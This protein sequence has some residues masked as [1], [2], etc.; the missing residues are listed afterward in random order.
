M[1]IHIRELMNNIEDS[2]VNIEEQNVVSSERIKELTRMKIQNTSHRKHASKKT[3]LTIGIAVAVVG[4]LGVTAFAALNGGLGR[5]SFGKSS[6]GPSI[7]EDIKNS[8]PAREFVSVVGYAD[9]P[10]Y[11]ATAEWLDFEDSY[12]SDR[13]ILEAHDA[14]IRRT[15]VDPFEEYNCYLV[16]SQE[17]V[18]KINEIT[19]KY[20]LKLHKNMT[21]CDEKVISQKYGNVFSGDFTGGGYMFEDG[22]FQLD[23]LC[24]GINFSIRRCMRGYFDTTYINVGDKSTFEEYTYTTKCGVTVTIAKGQNTMMGVERWIVTA[25]LEKSF[26]TV[27]IMGLDYDLNTHEYSNEEIENL[28]DQID[29]TKL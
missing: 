28:L 8:V 1:K 26:V 20:N 13:S 12:D 25:N 2:S 6:W 17:M 4:A 3:A 29:F 24:G 22:T 14:E 5:L 10:E 18:D 16:W 15:G 27:S 7:E 23:A 9:S 21:D 11:Q 19:A